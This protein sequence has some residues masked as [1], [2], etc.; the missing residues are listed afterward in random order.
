MQPYYKFYFSGVFE[1]LSIKGRV[2]AKSLDYLS[3]IDCFCLLKTAIDKANK[4]AQ[5]LPFIVDHFL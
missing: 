4:P 3:Y 1:Q 5:F 2:P